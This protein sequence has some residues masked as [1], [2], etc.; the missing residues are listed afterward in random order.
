VKERLEAA[1][2]GSTRGLGAP[3]TTTGGVGGA[4]AWGAGVGSRIAKPLRGGGDAIAS[5]PTIAGLQQSEQPGATG[6][7]RSSWFFS[8]QK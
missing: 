3:N 6:N 4:F 5:I 7:K 2:Q 1:K 8:G